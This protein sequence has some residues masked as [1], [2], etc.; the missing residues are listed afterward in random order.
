MNILTACKGQGTSLTFVEKIH[1]MFLP[2][3]DVPSSKP[4]AGLSTTINCSW[5]RRSPISN[6]SRSFST[7]LFGR[8]F[9]A[10]SFK[11]FRCIIR[12][13]QLECRNGL[14]TMFS[15]LPVTIKHFT[16]VFSCSFIQI[17]TLILWLLLTN[18]LTSSCLGL[19]GLISAERIF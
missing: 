6:C 19:R 1:L 18:S 4:G 2:I 12:E 8:F 7:K 10:P 14:L 9:A 17:V 15:T 11:E 16:R 3:H 13:V 5:M